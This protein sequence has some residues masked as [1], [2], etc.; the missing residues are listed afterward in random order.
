[1]PCVLLIGIYQ[2]LIGGE[3][4]VPFLDISY[5]DFFVDA[6]Y[7]GHPVNLSGWRERPKKH[8]ADPMGSDLIILYMFN[9]ISMAG[10][11]FS[12]RFSHRRY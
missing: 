2:C 5:L 4:G 7:W 1:M 6:R 12:P 11:L 3:Q 9:S 8:K 10:G